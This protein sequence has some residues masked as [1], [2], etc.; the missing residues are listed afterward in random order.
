MSVIKTTKVW[1]GL[2]VEE[3]TDT[4]TGVMELRSGSFLGTKGD[5]LATGDAKGKW[6]YNDQAGFRRRYNNKQRTQ[7]KQP[8]SQEQFNKKFFTEGTKSFNNDRAD[9][10]NTETN[11]SSQE[12]F[13]RNTKSFLENGIPSVKDPETGEVNTTEGDTIPNPENTNNDEQPFESLQIAEIPI[14]RR[15]GTLAYPIG[16]IPDLGYDFISFTAHEYQAG[17]LTTS[18]GIERLGTSLESIYLPMIPNIDETNSVSWGKDEMNALQSAGAEIAMKTIDS[19]SPGEAISN[20]MNS[21]GE[22]INNLIT[23]NDNL[24][25][26]LVQYF[27]GQAVGSNILGRASGSVLNPNLELLFSGPTLRT[28]NFTF[29]LRPRFP[30]EAERCKEIIRSFKRNM[31]VQR[32]TKEIFLKTP[33]IYKIKYYHNNTEEHPFMNRLKPCALV[34]FKVNYTP[35]NAYMTYPDGSMIGYDISLSFGE[36]APIYADEIDEQGG[37]SY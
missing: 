21:T 23:G 15:T 25:N 20:L 37:T 24:K 10:L 17:A 4:D 11:Y 5:L 34:N 31:N 35:D 36:I 14:A 26:Y 29:K 19:G 27:A 30:E 13:L 28:F 7:G 33:N 32:S 1:N 6:S 12:E 8:L 3:F 22:A 18:T 9:I 16:R 2:P